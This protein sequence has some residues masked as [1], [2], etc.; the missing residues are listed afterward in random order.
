MIFQQ[1]ERIHPNLH[2]R[3]GVHHH[4]GDHALATKL[5]PIG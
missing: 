3:I 2:F 4:D 5:N 1:S